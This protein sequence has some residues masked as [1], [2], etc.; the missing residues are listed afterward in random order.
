MLELS[1]SHMIQTGRIL[2]RFSYKDLE[3]SLSP[4]QDNR[5]KLT[6]RDSDGM[7][8]LSDRYNPKFD[9]NPL[10]IQPHELSRSFCYPSR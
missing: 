4:L 3:L 10:P 6:E 7:I 2:A 9:N 1:I 5:T 8:D